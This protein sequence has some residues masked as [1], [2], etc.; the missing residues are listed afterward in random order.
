VRHDQRK[1][2]FMFAPVAS[3]VSAII[4]ES[5]NSGGDVG[6]ATTAEPAAAGPNATADG[7]RSYQRAGLEDQGT[8]RWLLALP[9]AAAVFL[10]VGEISGETRFIRKEIISIFTNDAIGAAPGA[11]G[12]EGTPELLANGFGPVHARGFKLV[13]GPGSAGW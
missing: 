3:R 6:P 11:A 8:R 12:V 1:G 10:W 9:A 5:G 13:A 7:L 2:A 4:A